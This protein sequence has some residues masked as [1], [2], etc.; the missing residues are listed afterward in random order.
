MSG[1][2]KEKGNE[3]FEHTEWELIGNERCFLEL[4]SL[5][6]L[7]NK[8]VR[9]TIACP[10]KIKRERLFFLLDDFRFDCSSVYNECVGSVCQFFQVCTLIKILRFKYIK[11]SD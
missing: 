8:I 2:N 10:Y 6:W 3:V 1:W 11:R 7:R 5:H 4:Y 9:E